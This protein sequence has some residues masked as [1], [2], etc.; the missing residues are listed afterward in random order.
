M[1]ASEIKDKLKQRYSDAYLVGF[2]IVGIGTGSKVIG[3]ILGLIIGIGSLF[4]YKISTYI[5]VAGVVISLLVWLLCYLF[6]VLI[7][8]QGQ[9]LRAPLDSAVN[10]S[11][12]LSDSDKLEMVFASLFKNSTSPQVKSLPQQSIRED[13]TIST[14]C[15]KCGLSLTVKDKFFNSTGICKKCLA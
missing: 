15:S 2:T 13:E 10:S 6:G 3:A 12:V 14:H 9:V 5:V 11:P 1:N 7:S 4:T 8:A